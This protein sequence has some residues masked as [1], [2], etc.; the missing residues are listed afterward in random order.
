MLRWLGP[1]AG[2]FM[3]LP[4][5]DRFSWTDVIH[6]LDIDLAQLLDE[7]APATG[8]EELLSEWQPS[9]NDLPNL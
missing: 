7:D 4:S 5:H 6:C 1:Q 3:V 9:V 8:V 2:V